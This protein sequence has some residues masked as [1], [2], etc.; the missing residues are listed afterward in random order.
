M[1]KK[2]LISAVAKD[3]ELSKKAVEQAFTSIFK[4]IKDALGRRERIAIKGFGTFSVKDRAAKTGRHPKTGDMLQI[5]ARTVP[6]FSA[7]SDL[8]SVV[9][10]SGKPKKKSTKKKATKKKATK[11]KA[12]KKATAKKA[13]KKKATK[14]KSSKKKK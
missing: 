2:E 10:E 14:K 8:K 7:G 1:N 12:T 6:S 3:T 9:A 11:K 4:T 5:P 13:T